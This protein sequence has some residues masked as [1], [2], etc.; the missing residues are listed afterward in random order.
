VPMASMPHTGFQRLDGG[1]TTIIMDTG[2]PPPPTVSQDAHAGCLSFELS[3]GASR[4]ITNCGM[5]ATGRDNWRAFA[6]ETVAHTDLVYRETSS[7]EFVA[8]TAMKRFLQGAPIIAGP[9]HVEVYRE[10]TSEGVLLTASHNGYA[11][12]FGLIHRRSILLS[13]DGTR[14]DGEDSLEPVSGGEVRGDDDF[15]VRFHLHPSIKASRLADGRAVM[16][17]LP[18]RDVWTFEALDDRVELEDSVF[19]AGSDGPRRT[20]QVVIHQRARTAPRVRWSI[21][22][23]A[24][25]STTTSAARRSTRHEPELPL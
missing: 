7:C 6:R 14:I 18:N 22:R 3:V 2:K 16:L 8:L 24:A 12:Q 13:E 15:A 23:S 1:A 21:A 5:P 11:G 19:L 4:I 10:T 9:T 25:S 17:V 20:T